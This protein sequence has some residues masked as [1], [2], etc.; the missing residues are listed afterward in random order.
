MRHSATLAFRST[1]SLALVFGAGLLGV[2][3]SADMAQ[4]NNDGNEPELGE[5]E[6]ERTDSIDWAVYIVDSTHGID[7]R[8]RGRT[9]ETAVRTVSWVLAN[10]PEPN[11]RIQIVDTLYGARQYDL[12]AATQHFV[13]DTQTVEVFPWTPRLETERL[14]LENH[15]P[16][17]YPGVFG[18]GDATIFR[19]V[20]DTR[21]ETGDEAEEEGEPLRSKL[22]YVRMSGLAFQKSRGALSISTA[23]DPLDDG[24][25]TEIQV[26]LDNVS[27][28]EFDGVAVQ[29]SSYSDRAIAL[30][31]NECEFRQ[32]MTGVA[33]HAGADGRAFAQVSNSRFS[34]SHRPLAPSVLFGGSVDVYAG[35]RSIVHVLCDRL[36][37]DN[38]TFA[39]ELSTATRTSSDADLRFVLRNSQVSSRPTFTP[40]GCLL[41]VSGKSVLCETYGA[42]RLNAYPD[43]D[44]R[45]DVINNTFWQ[46][47]GP[48]VFVEQSSGRGGLGGDKVEVSLRNNLFW[49]DADY[50]VSAE[51]SAGPSNVQISENERF[52]CEYNLMPSKW[53]DDQ[54]DLPTS[55]LFTNPM[56]AGGDTPF[57]D[58]FALMPRS[59]AIDAGDP[60]FDR[61]AQ[62]VLDLNDACRLTGRDRD[63][64]GKVD[65]YRVDIGAVEY[66]G[67]CEF[68]RIPEFRRG[69]CRIDDNVE[70]SDAIFL[71]GFLFLGQ[72]PPPC[73]D[74]CDSN[75]D[76]GLDITDG[77]Y[78]LSYLFL[79]GAAP[80]EPFDEPGVDP[81]ADP[82]ST[83]TYV[84]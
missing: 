61:T 5:V 76:G 20:P 84:P 51:S 79:G 7:E 56:F 54:A 60:V 36:R 16:D 31:V 12:P 41:G 32:T 19:S 81:S 53:R 29:L 25:A 57:N 37:M 33:I 71:F 13:N 77:V 24:S 65:R 49:G 45:C 28:H 9:P 22:R 70:L 30:R 50:F 58:N 47:S 82:L 21:E 17:W 8:G 62:G 52:E 1:I 23:N 73:P 69:D 11:L 83:C 18:F 75:D 2:L 43:F 59:P 55:N 64:D 66:A 35:E 46:L 72:Q 26:E 10:A 39:A 80:A 48:A 3:A 15:I 74:A 6:F 40:G 14:I 4:A 78:V 34:S 63:G 38:V 27:F 68:D 42:V 67:D 44:V